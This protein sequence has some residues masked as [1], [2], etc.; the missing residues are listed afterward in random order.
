MIAQWINRSGSGGLLIFFNGWG[1]DA[2]PFSRLDSIGLDILM[3]YDY[4][5]LE[6]LCDIAA[7]TKEYSACH[8][9]AWSLGV[10]AA[11]SALS[12]RHI[13]FSSSVAI[14]G[15]LLPINAENGIAPEIFQG[16]VDSWNAVTRKKFYRRMCVSPEIIAAF[17][18]SEPERAA[19]SQ[20]QELAAIQQ[21]VLRQSPLSCRNLFNRAVIGGGDRIFPAAAQEKFWTAA[22]VSHKIAV[23]PHYP[24]SG[25]RHWK[26]L[27]DFEQD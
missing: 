18:N 16:T 26:E 11:A 2:K 20:R 15:T 6:L 27:I 17:C 5:N 24:F 14:N 4:S 7:I 10:W 9:A 23:A 21:M 1:M 19:D 3:F 13:Q 8:L 22:G 25:L 12:G